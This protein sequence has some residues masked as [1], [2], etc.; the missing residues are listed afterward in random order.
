MCGAGKRLFHGKDDSLVSD[1][2]A[3][4]CASADGEERDKVVTRKEG[5]TDG[6]DCEGGLCLKRFDYVE[7]GGMGGDERR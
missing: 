3:S 5:G 4:A 1:L 2:E 7:W 6:I